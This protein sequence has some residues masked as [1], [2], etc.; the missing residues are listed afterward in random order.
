MAA[1]KGQRSGWLLYIARLNEFSS[2]AV[3]LTTRPSGSGYSRPLFSQFNRR[4]VS[5]WKNRRIGGKGGEW[6]EDEMRRRDQP[7]VRSGMPNAPMSAWKA[8]SASLGRALV[9]FTRLVSF[10]RSRLAALGWFPAPSVKGY[11]SR[12]DSASTN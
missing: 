7:A 2:T 12:F 1:K 9:S 10:G 4:R 11:P 8:A 3:L 6:N 5:A